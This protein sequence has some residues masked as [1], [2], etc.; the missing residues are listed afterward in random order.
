MEI[1]SQELSSAAILS[2]ATQHLNGLIRQG[3][4]WHYPAN[5]SERS[6][7]GSSSTI[8][9]GSLGGLSDDDHTIYALLAGRSGGQIYKGGTA[10]G[11]D[12]QLVATSNA[13][14]SGAEIR[15]YASTSDT[16]QIATITRDATIGYLQCFTQASSGQFNLEFYDATTRKWT[17]YKTTTHDFA[18]YE[19]ATDN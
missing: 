5:G 13:S 7:L 18:L 9:H 10:A 19:D 16:R 12:L 14:P 2:L 11:D 4:K 6:C 1:P 15:L 8:D 17:F 3:I